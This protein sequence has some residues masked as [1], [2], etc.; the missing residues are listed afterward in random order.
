MHFR[1][2]SAMN[3]EE[4]I[5]SALSSLKTKNFIKIRSFLWRKS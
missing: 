5:G 2:I 1:E 3:I 4:M